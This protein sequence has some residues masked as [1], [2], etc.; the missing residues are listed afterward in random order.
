[1]DT[2]EKYEELKTNTI[3]KVQNFVVFSEDYLTYFKG[4]SQNVLFELQKMWI[5]NF[6]RTWS[7][8]YFVVPI[9]F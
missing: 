6:S 9:C 8:K 2:I 4:V 3:E 7:P 5:E 1:M